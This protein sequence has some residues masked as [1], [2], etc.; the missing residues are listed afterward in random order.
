MQYVRW[1]IR[2][3]GEDFLE[4][5]FGF[6]IIDFTCGQQ[7]INHGCVFCSI[8]RTG[9]EIIFSSECNRPDAILDQVIVDLEPTV[10]NI[11]D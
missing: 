1:A 4:P 2:Q 8:V 11:S 10:I 3:H 9:K 6:D 7:G 5:C